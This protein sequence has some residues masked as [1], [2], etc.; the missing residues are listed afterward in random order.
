MNSSESVLLDPDMI[1]SLAMAVGTP[2]FAAG[3]LDAADR[4]GG[5]DE[6]FGYRISSEA[7]IPEVM[8]SSSMLPDAPLRVSLYRQH[9]HRF[10][11]F[12]SGRPIAGVGTGIVGRV[13]ADEIVNRNYRA[14][15]FDTPRFKSKSCFAW[16]REHDVFV[17]N[18]YHRHD[19][20]IL[21]SPRFTA[22]GSLGLSMLMLDHKKRAARADPLFTRLEQ[23]LR[24][25]FP[26]LSLR[27]RQVCG[28]TL[29]GWSAKRIA[30]DLRIAPNT[31]LTYRKRAYDRTGIARAAELL[32]GII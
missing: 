5:A 13:R 28:R 7:A 4:V 21:H 10:D 6:I 16:R 12:L 11:P 27:E 19:L 2:E 22:L 14:H 24:A 1:G 26:A 8:I 17:L 18:F 23:A 3:I 15:C 29:A 25:A 30:D 32:D 9:F 20:E 31:V